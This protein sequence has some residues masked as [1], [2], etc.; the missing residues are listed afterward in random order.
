MLCLQ[1]I[2]YPFSIYKSVSYLKPC[3]H[4]P[5]LWVK[6]CTEKEIFFR[7]S[8]LIS[9]TIM[10]YFDDGLSLRN[11]ARNDQCNLSF[12]PCDLLMKWLGH[13]LSLGILTYLL[14]FT[15]VL[16][17]AVSV[18]RD[19]VTNPEFQVDIIYMIFGHMSSGV[20]II[21]FHV[22]FSCLR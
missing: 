21:C 20:I 9:F 18:F 10:F 22:I 13:F 12:C 17:G 5:Q 3:D 8:V 19:D 15:V 6:S 2:H 14:W 16:R 1:V 11:L 7:G 4:F